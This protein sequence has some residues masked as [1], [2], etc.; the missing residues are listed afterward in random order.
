MLFSK[1]NRT[2]IVNAHD[3]TNSEDLIDLQEVTVFGSG[4][5]MSS[6][7]DIHYGSYMSILF[8]GSG[9]IEKTLTDETTSL[10]IDC[11][12]HSDHT[13]IIT[14]VLDPTQTTILSKR[15]IGFTDFPQK[16]TLEF[17]SG[18]GQTLRVEAVDNQIDLYN[19]YAN[20][21]LNTKGYR[22]LGF[23]TT[24][25]RDWPTLMEL[26]INYTG[27]SISPSSTEEIGTSIND[28]I[29]TD[30]NYAYGIEK[31]QSTD[32]KLSKMFDGISNQHGDGRFTFKNAGNNRFYF[33]ITLVNP[34]PDVTSFTYWTGGAGGEVD[35]FAFMNLT[36]YG[37][38]QNP[39]TMGTNGADMNILSNWTFLSNNFT[40]KKFS[41]YS[42]P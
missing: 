33:Y 26:H 40:K 30:F 5:S 15:S 22:Y 42:Y 20:A 4:I 32:G 28:T 34:I 2:T 24:D 21:G 13:Y 35:R 8:T 1:I 9:Y 19:I 6:G 12:A 31:E 41:E 29:G 38:N 3:S 25:V 11:K 17:S 27:G 37:T 39:M 7:T 16:I 36:I 18:I 14:T 10:T 23:Y